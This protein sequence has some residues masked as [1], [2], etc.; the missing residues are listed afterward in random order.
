VVS[1]VGTAATPVVRV[2]NRNGFPAGRAV[3]PPALTAVLERIGTALKPEPGTVQ[4]VDYTDNEPIHTVQFPSNFQ[5]STARAKAASAA[6]ART[7]GNASRLSAE[8][9]ADADPIASNT[10]AEGREQNRRIEIVLHRPE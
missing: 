3:L 2:G 9:R 7:L 6:V 4:V 10:T 8:G 1:V 5:L